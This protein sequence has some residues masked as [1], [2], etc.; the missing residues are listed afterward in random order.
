MDKKPSMTITGN[1][2]EIKLTV[3]YT[4]SIIFGCFTKERFLY[5]DLEQCHRKI[6]LN[7]KTIKYGK[8][9]FKNSLN[10]TKLNS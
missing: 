4:R 7:P 1:K 9:F 10:D 3:L 5:F 8:K 2:N 6:V